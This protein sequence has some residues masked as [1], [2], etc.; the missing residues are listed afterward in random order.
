[1]SIIRKDCGLMLL[2]IALQVLSSEQHDGLACSACCAAV[3]VA[4]LQ[5]M[6]AGNEECNTSH[7]LNPDCTV[8]K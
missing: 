2:V 1:M 5:S 7:G 6:A 3:A 8:H 4:E